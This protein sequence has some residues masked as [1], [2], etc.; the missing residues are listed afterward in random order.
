M[1]RGAL[2]END[3]RARAFAVRRSHF[4]DEIN[5][6]APGLKRFSTDEFEQRNPRAFLPISLTGSAC[7]LQCDHCAAKILDPMLPLNHKEGLFSLC[8]RL[9]GSGTEGVLISGGSSVNGGVPIH[10]HI[11]D[12]ARIKKELPLRVPS[13]SLSA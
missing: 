1:A 4:P 2:T 11:D 12:I 13:A 6:Y 3:L 8:K 5:F 10:K 7:V 9:A